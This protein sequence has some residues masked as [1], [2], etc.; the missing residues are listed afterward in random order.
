[1]SG[2]FGWKVIPGTADPKGGKMWIYR[3]KKTRGE[4]VLHDKIV[5]IFNKLEHLGSPSPSVL[6]PRFARCPSVTFCD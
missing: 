6:V 5:I 3:I 1:M 2:S 4:T